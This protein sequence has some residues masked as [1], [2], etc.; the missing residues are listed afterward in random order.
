MS[1]E[2]QELK[3]SLFIC[4]R[5]QWSQH[6]GIQVVQARPFV[7]IWW[8]CLCLYLE[9][10]QNFRSWQTSESYFQQFWVKLQCKKLHS[11]VIYVAYRAP[12]CPVSC[13]EDHLK[14]SLIEALTLSKLIIILGYLNCNTLKESYESKA[15]AN[16]CTD[17]NLKQMISTL[18]FWLITT[19][20]S[21]HI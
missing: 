7:K 14:P 6:W 15:L 18:L 5:L 12:H 19:V 1:V 9:R 17:V 21:C 4:C 10:H 11:V 13:F 2:T 3:S 16:F 20:W 8:R